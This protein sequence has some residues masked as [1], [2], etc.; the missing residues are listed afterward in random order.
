VARAPG[1][2]GIAVVGCGT[3]GTLRARLLARHAAVGR[4][5]LHDRD[6]ARAAQTAADCGDVAEVVGHL[7]EAVGDDRVD[8]IVV[9]TSEDQHVEPA[10]AALQ[11]GKPVLVEKPLAH[12]LS[13]AE[14]ILDAAERTS[15]ALYVG[16][17]QRFRRRFLNAKQQIVTGKVGSITGIAGKRYTGRAV[18]EKIL[19]RTTNVTPAG[20]SLTYVADL[21]LWYLDGARPTSVVAYNNYASLPD[22]RSAP[23]ASWAL[24]EFD[25]GAIANLSVAWQLPRTHPTQ[26]VIGM[27]VFGDRGFL[28]IDDSHR[29]SVMS[30]ELPADLLYTP[31]VQLHAAFIGTTPAGDWA[32]GR[33]WGAMKEETYAFVDALATAE[34]HPV[35]ASGAQGRNVLALTEAID[36]AARERSR[37]DL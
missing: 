3:I 28:S 1:S 8:A 19:R 11:T 34:P 22:G 20:D 23:E 10:L 37:V 4:L 15:T 18:R 6:G 29:E 12:R 24:V 16:Y 13:E 27:D 21:C 14:R 7:D 30:S 9:S 5:L 17:T 32:L 33:F 26:F 2:L 31:D 35:L 36:T 25:T